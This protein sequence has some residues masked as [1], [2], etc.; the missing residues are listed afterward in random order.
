MDEKGIKI[1]IGR[2]NRRKREK[3][4]GYWGLKTGGGK[5][6]PYEKKRKRMD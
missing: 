6:Q 2:T 4:T 3:T 5:G 1:G